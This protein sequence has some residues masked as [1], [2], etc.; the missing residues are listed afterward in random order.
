MYS[1]IGILLVFA[2]MPDCSDAEFESMLVFKFWHIARWYRT[3]PNGEPIA[4]LN[5]PLHWRSPGYLLVKF[6][7]GRNLHFNN[8]MFL[9]QG[10]R[11]ELSGPNG[12]QWWAEPFHGQSYFT[13][14]DGAAHCQ[15]LKFNWQGSGYPLRSL[16]LTRTSSNV[17]VGRNNHGESWCLL[18]RD[19]EAPNDQRFRRMVRNAQS[20]R[21]ADPNL[22]AQ[23]SPFS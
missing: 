23:L 17:F 6:E 15:S 3:M 13:H 14:K 19:Y 5:D 12:K 21:N 7:T 18:F 16:D 8:V 9:H 1:F 20:V 2:S 11:G 10:L 4:H 22:A